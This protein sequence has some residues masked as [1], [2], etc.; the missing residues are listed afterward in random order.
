MVVVFFII[1]LIL[2]GTLFFWAP[3]VKIVLKNPTTDLLSRDCIERWC[4][5]NRKMFIFLTEEHSYFIQK[6]TLWN[7]VWLTIHLRSVRHMVDLSWDFTDP[8]LLFA[9]LSDGLNYDIFLKLE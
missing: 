4:R 7:Y 8:N 5:S 6:M 3:N 1:C 9:N 2:F